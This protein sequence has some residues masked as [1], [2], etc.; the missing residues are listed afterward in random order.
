MYVLDKVGNVSFV[1]IKVIKS[2]GEKSLVYD[3]RF[4]DET[5]KEHLTVEIYDVVLKN[6]K[7][8]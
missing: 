1:P 5:G 8:S 6:P 2:D 7:E 3:T 4:Y